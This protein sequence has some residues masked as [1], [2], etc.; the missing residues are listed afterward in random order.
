MMDISR[1]TVSG[2]GHLLLL[3]LPINRTEET[4]YNKCPQ[5]HP[6]GTKERTQVKFMHCHRT[7]IY[8]SLLYAIYSN[9]VK[10][11]VFRIIA[12][13]QPVTWAYEKKKKK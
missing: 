12:S 13:L 8:L 5:K 7:T 6:S 4:L 9:T 1:Q 10:E 2:D 11:H 3:L